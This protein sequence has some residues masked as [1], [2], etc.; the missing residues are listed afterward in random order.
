MNKSN[1]IE[2]DQNFPLR[3]SKSESF[4]ANI[5]KKNSVSRV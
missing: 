3:Q 4:N 5:Y 1:Q 2:K